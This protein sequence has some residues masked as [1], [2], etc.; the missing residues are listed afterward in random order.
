VSRTCEWVGW[1][2]ADLTSS[3]RVGILLFSQRLAH[4]SGAE[5][6]CIEIDRPSS[7]ITHDVACEVGDLVSTLASVALE[8]SYGLAMIPAVLG[9]LSVTQ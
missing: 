4:R 5:R 6:K 2:A 1:R 7:V 3:R 9:L 8:L